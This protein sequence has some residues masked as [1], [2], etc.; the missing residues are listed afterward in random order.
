MHA[1][2]GL[3][4]LVVCDCL[5]VCLSLCLS[6]KSHLTSGASVRHE[7]TVTYSA[8][9]GGHNICGVF[10][11]AAPLQRYTA[12]Y[13]YPRS[14]P[15]W[16]C[17]HFQLFTHAYYPGFCTKTLVHSLLTILHRSTHVNIDSMCTCTVCCKEHIIAA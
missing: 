9:N 5:S 15:F 11:E 10:A 17:V 3:L 7:N 6:V 16:K 2:R 8:G 14:W 12:L 13:G 4:Y 1:Q